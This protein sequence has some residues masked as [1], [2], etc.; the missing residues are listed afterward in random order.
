MGTLL[1]WEGVCRGVIT[2]HGLHEA[3]SGAKAINIVAQ[4][5]DY[6]DRDMT[7][8][9]VPVGWTDCRGNEWEVDG[10]IWIIKKDGSI[11][12]SQA[13]ALMQHAGWDGNFAK[14]ESWQPTPCAFTIQKDEYKNQVRYRI[15]WLNPYDAEPGGVTNVSP[16]RAKELQ[17]QYGSQFRALAGNVTRAATP[18][19]QGAPATPAAPE[20]PKTPDTALAPGPMDNDDVPF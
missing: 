7:D 1:N 13:E 17:N 11:N 15:A 4:V 9:G 6:Y 18:A 14:L 19:P 3:D 5:H 12:Q 20:T 16:E 8:K 10:A 2:E